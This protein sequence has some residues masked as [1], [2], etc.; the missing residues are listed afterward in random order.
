MNN[1]YNIR[2][3]LLCSS[4]SW[5]SGVKPHNWSPRA[6]WFS[7]FFQNQ[8]NVKFIQNVSSVGAQKILFRC[9]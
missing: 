3:L 9:L 8:V 1:S 7:M 6:D 2:I 5:K 4:I